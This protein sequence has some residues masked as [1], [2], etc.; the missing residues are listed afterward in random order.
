[1]GCF[2]EMPLIA[3]YAAE[4]DMPLP[5]NETHPARSQL[6]TRVLGVLGKRLVVEVQGLVKVLGQLGPA[7]LIEEFPGLSRTRQTGLGNSDEQAN[8]QQS[9]DPPNGA[10][11]AASKP[12]AAIRNFLKTSC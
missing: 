12:G 10:R 3:L 1:M 11:A 4:H 5:G 9:N 7:G 8:R 2:L 6:V